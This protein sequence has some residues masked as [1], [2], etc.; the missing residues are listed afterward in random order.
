MNE[1][2]DE[3]ELFDPYLGL[4]VADSWWI[5]GRRLNKLRIAKTEAARTVALETWA[6]EVWDASDDC[7]TV[8]RLNVVTSTSLDLFASNVLRLLAAKYRGESIS[9]E[10]HGLVH[11]TDYAIRDEG[12]FLI[13]DET[14]ATFWSLEYYMLFSEL[15]SEGFEPP[16]WLRAVGICENER[17]NRFFIRQRIDN[18]FDTESCRTNRATYKRKRRH[19]KS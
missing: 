3:V 19:P 10:V 13:F 16:G 9:A 15:D 4:A 11:P 2:R 18:R 1:G 7:A 6:K 8:R 5:L 14:A 12:R 17:C